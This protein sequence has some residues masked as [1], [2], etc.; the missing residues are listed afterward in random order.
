MANTFQ[1][2]DNLGD[3]NVN[4]RL[5]YVLGQ[6][7]GVKE[8]QQEQ[9]YFLNKAQV[10]NHDLHGYG[11]VEGLEVSCTQLEERSNL[12][13]KGEWLIKVSPGLAIDQQGREIWINQELDKEQCANLNKWLNSTPHPDKPNS[14]KNYVNVGELGKRKVLYI[15]LC[16]SDCYTGEQLILGEP[17]RTDADT[18]Q[19]TRIRDNFELK[20][21]P[22]LPRQDEECHVRRIRELFNQINIDPN[23][24]QPKINDQSYPLQQFIDELYKEINK[25]VGDRSKRFIVPK[26]MAYDVLHKLLQYWVSNT[27][28]I[29][30]EIYDPKI[31]IH[32]KNRLFT[33]ELVA[34]HFREIQDYLASYCEGT[35]S[36]AGTDLFTAGNVAGVQIGKLRSLQELLAKVKIQ[37]NIQ[38]LS[39]TDIKRLKNE[40]LAARNNPGQLPEISIP[41]L[42]S[43]KI[44][45]EL[46]SASIEAINLPVAL[47]QKFDFLILTE[48]DIIVSDENLSEQIN[49][50]KKKY[51]LYLHTG[52]SKVLDEVPNFKAMEETQYRAMQQT[53]N[54]LPIQ[55]DC[56][57]LARIQFNLETST[58]T[59]GEKTVTVVKDVIV[60]T[61][62]RPYLLHTRLLQELIKR[63]EALVSQLLVRTDEIFCKDG[64]VGISQ[65]DPET[66]LH[67]KG[68]RIRL[69]STDRNKEFDL[70]LDGS[71]TVDLKAE[72][73]G[74]NIQSKGDLSIYST[75]IN[76]KVLINPA[77]ADGNVGIGTSDPHDLL[78]IGEANGRG[79]TL[80]GDEGKIAPFLTINNPDNP[81][82]S[83]LTAR[84]GYAFN[85]E[86]PV[87]KSC[88]SIDIDKQVGIGTSEPQAKLHVR[89]D[90]LEE[91]NAEIQGN[92]TVQGDLYL[93]QPEQYL[94]RPNDMVAIRPRPSIPT[95]DRP[96]T[97]LVDYPV[98]TLQEGDAA[99]FSLLRPS[100]VRNEGPPNAFLRIYC[101]A[102]KATTDGVTITWEV[103]WRWVT[104]IGPIAT[105]NPH[106]E[107]DI[108]LPRHAGPGSPLPAGIP[109]RP[110][111]L[112]RDDRLAALLPSN[113]FSGPIETKMAIYGQQI[114]R[115]YRHYL[116]VS[117]FLT[118]EPDDTALTADYLV[119]NLKLKDSNDLPA[120]HLIM[121]E[122]RL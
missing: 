16:H 82:P 37:R 84:D 94:V 41:T 75:G 42:Q 93:N 63:H 117:E 54:G 90:F 110:E 80:K 88:L 73:S 26:N 87:G 17:C 113:D 10:Q 86:Y 35:A 74:L 3:F 14:T 12:G 36:I 45:P 8:F 43:A 18:Q 66:K 89:G 95:P 39:E 58:S 2:Q 59:N 106:R 50:I 44:L 92:L 68:D 108:I 78:E 46:V 57:V 34:D 4:E 122:L 49:V 114:G 71:S 101:T 27:R 61:T 11:T 53:I 77:Y 105:E 121:A 118:L 111:H 21:S 67:V 65:P 97:T 40:F 25:R 112:E 20:L 96:V 62:Q 1:S 9:I 64:K 85:F 32:K 56:I 98:L 31:L 29:L 115:E 100:R 47:K 116:H 33:N 48:K 55:D 51:Q 5:N 83:I 52:D 23:L 15:T 103:R 24:N 30:S 104:A 28:K 99:K 22:T 72:K 109:R 102:D 7:L 6:V 81:D 119:I 38:S 60:D 76:H 19:P 70:Q 120:V 69:E 79:L 13:E 107:P 91:G